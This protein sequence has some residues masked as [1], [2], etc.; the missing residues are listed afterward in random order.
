LFYKGR[1]E[2]SKAV[3]YDEAAIRSAEKWLD[4][5]PNDKPWVLFLPLLFPH[6]PF[7]VEEPYFSMYK[8]EDMPVQSSHE[9]KV[10]HR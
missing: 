10:W 4:C 5:S 3:D 1:R 9:Q 7:T 6:C 2:V 8:R